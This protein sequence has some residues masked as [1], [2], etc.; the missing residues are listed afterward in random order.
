MNTKLSAYSISHEG[1]PLDSCGF[2]SGSYTNSVSA[3]QERV[4][5]ALHNYGA[6]AILPR[7]PLQVGVYD[8]SATVNDH[9]YDW[10]FTVIR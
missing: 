10:S 3:D 9:R 8:V 4:R 7:E 5:N 6:V 2:D 1:K